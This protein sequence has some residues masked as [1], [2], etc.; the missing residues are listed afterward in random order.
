[1]WKNKARGEGTRVGEG[2]Y[3]FIG[4][5]EKE[6]NPKDVAQLQQYHRFLRNPLDQFLKINQN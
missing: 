2:G 6:K 3:F 1:M 5:S 4:C